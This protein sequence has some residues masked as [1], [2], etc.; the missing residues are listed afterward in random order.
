VLNDNFYRRMRICGACVSVC[1]SN[2]LEL[3]EMKIIAREGCEECAFCRVVCPL[4]A[5]KEGK[6]EI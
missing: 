6:N 4:G 1:P 2:I 3:S 5:I